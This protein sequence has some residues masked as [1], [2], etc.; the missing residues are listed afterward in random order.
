MQ[1][2]KHF[3]LEELTTTS[4][5]ADNTPDTFALGKLRELAIILDFIYDQIGPFRV[6]SAYRSPAVN[7]IIGGSENSFHMRGMAADL[8]PLNT[9][10]R[11]FFLKIAKSPLSNSLGEIIDESEEKG[12]VHVSL[13]SPEKRSMFMWLESGNYLRFSPSDVAVL[14]SGRYPTASSYSIDTQNVYGTQDSLGLGAIAALAV[15]TGVITL[16]LIVARRR[17]SG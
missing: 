13:P 2:S 1:L 8:R 6:N 9:S 12:V 3:T 17:K 11:E 16:V 4:Q 7:S 15:A 5:S 14:K 10:A